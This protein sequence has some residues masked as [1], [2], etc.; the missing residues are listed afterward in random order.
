METT[1]LLLFDVMT[2]SKSTQRRFAIGMNTKTSYAY[3]GFGWFEVCVCVIVCEL[4]I[5][6]RVEGV[7]RVL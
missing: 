4:R 7:G 6:G 5:R 1:T 3:T 2:G